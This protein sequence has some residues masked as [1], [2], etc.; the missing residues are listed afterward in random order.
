M[1]PHATE[2]LLCDEGHCQ[3][4]KTTAYRLGKYLH[5]FYIQQRVIKS[6]IYKE[7]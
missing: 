6:R 5:E 4:D 7:L 1:E 2:N 3:L